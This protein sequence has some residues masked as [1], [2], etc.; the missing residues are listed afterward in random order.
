M[1]AQTASHPLASSLGPAV[2]LSEKCRLH[3]LVMPMP[4][5]FSCCWYCVSDARRICAEDGVECPDPRNH[6]VL[7]DSSVG[8]HAWVI[9]AIKDAGGLR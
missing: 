2:T 9:Q 3:G 1:V 4:D 6:I 8:P 7:P 5:A